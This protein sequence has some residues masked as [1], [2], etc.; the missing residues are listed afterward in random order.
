M[1]IQG[2]KEKQKKNTRISACDCAKSQPFVSFKP[3]SFD[4]DEPVSETRCRTVLHFAVIVYVD[5]QLQVGQAA[6]R[7]KRR[8][9]VIR[10]ISG[11][12]H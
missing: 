7:R 6:A 4:I 1:R 11:V 9:A 10:D 3:A 5:V 8:K 2:P 12:D